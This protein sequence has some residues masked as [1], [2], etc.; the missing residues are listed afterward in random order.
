MVVL[1]IA[2]FNSRQLVIHL[3]VLYDWTRTQFLKL[4][5]TSSAYKF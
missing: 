5:Y 4:S 2:Q 1:I 3:Y